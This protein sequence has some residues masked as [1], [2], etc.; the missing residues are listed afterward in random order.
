MRNLLKLHIV[1]VAVVLLAS[2]VFIVTPIGEISF[3]HK[4]T[5]QPDGQCISDLVLIVANCSSPI[6]SLSSPSYVGGTSDCQS[7]ARRRVFTAAALS[8]LA[9][10]S[11]GPWVLRRRKAFPLGQT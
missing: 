9:I 2:V 11:L 6:T 1:A 5:P 10:S 4:C 7:V 3:G 8:F